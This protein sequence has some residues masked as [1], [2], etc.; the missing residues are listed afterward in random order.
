MGKCD[1]EMLDRV[2]GVS[3]FLPGL[4]IIGLV[5]WSCEM[6]WHWGVLPWKPLPIPL[7]LDQQQLGLLAI[8][9][10]IVGPCVVLVATL[11]LRGRICTEGIYYRGFIRS[12]FVPWSTICELDDSRKWFTFRIRTKERKIEMIRLRRRGGHLAEDLASYLRVLKPET[13]V[14]AD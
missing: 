11:R 7:D 1:L 8:A 2:Y 3:A 14:S 6:L 4:G 5:F 12:F 10:A 13:I 9:I